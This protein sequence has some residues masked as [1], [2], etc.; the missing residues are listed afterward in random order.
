MEGEQII[1][2]IFQKMRQSLV[3]MVNSKSQRPLIAF[4]AIMRAAEVEEVGCL[5]NRSTM[6]PFQKG[7]PQMPNCLCTDH[8]HTSITSDST[9][10]LTRCH[11]GVTI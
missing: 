4:R 7:N 6:G 5:Q 1:M 3:N 2:T 10:A 8:D 11:R 9:T